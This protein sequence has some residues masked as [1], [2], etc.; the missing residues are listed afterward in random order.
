MIRIYIYMYMYYINTMRGITI[1]IL[2]NHIIRR[3]QGSISPCSVWEIQSCQH[4]LKITWSPG[5]WRI[6]RI[7]SHSGDIR[8]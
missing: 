4:N 3:S 6:A 7:G 1:T 2:T 8:T 5:Q